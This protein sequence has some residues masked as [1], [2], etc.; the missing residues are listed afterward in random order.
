M[1]TKN[2]FQVF[3]V[4]LRSLAFLRI[5][6]ASIILIDLMIRSQHME[7]HYTDQGVLPRDIVIEYFSQW[8]ISLH[9]LSGL[10]EIQY[11]IFLISGIFAFLM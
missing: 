7:A 4:D 8:R 2:F 10:L 5:A 1:K 6:L 9:L 3:T 11:L